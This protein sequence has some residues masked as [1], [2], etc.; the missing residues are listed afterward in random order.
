[1]SQ[2]HEVIET[3]YGLLD[4][5]AL[6]QVQETYDTTALL[7]AVEQLDRMLAGARDADGLRDMLL[8][9]HGMAHTVV[10]GAGMSV[11]TGEDTLPELAA[12]IVAD[13]RQMIQQLQEWISRIEPIEDLAPRN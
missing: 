10:N 12:D 13:M 8:R 6:E 3:A 1:M 2:S 7:R 5:G 4:R 9:L 11:P